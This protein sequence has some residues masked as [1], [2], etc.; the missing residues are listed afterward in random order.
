MVELSLSTVVWK[1]SLPM[2]TRDDG[3]RG[4]GE[5]LRLLQN[6]EEVGGDIP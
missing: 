6:N 3:G 4:K 5:A 1:T 2:E